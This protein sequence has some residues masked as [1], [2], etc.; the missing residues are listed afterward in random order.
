METVIAAL[1]G[2]IGGGLLSFIAS[3]IVGHLNHIRTLKRD[4]LNNDNQL[5]RDEIT[6]KRSEK[7]RIYAKFIK[8]ATLLK[9]NALSTEGVESLTKESLESILDSLTIYEV[10][11]IADEYVNMA[12]HNFIEKVLQKIHGKPFEYEDIPGFREN[13]DNYGLND[14]LICL[15]NTMRKDIDA[16]SVGLTDTSSISQFGLEGWGHGA[17]MW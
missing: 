4:E 6:W 7:V 14:A 5:R 1:I 10:R 12:M 9:N 17:E 3:L 16:Q 2:G 15:E 13:V 8:R 11:L